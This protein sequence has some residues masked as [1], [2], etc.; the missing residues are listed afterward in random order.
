MP[1]QV[2]GRAAWHAQHASLELPALS[3]SRAAKL[4]SP[5]SLVLRNVS[6][7]EVS[8]VLSSFPGVEEANVYGVQ[9]HRLS[10]AVPGVGSVSRNPIG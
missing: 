5:V 9:A 4:A 7:M 1:R 10:G 3:S 8:Q 6:T 2:E